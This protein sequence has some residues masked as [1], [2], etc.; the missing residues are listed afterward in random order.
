MTLAGFARSLGPEGLVVV[1][2]DRLAL[3]LPSRGAACF[4]RIDRL[5]SNAPKG[6][7]LRFENITT[8]DAPRTHAR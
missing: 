2:A 6:A 7:N 3:E 1:R 4:A 8:L 5:V